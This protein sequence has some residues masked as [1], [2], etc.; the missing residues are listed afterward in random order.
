MGQAMGGRVPHFIRRFRIASVTMTAVVLALLLLPGKDIPHVDVPNV[1]KAVHFA[2]FWLWSLVLLYDW[3]S[4]ATRVPLLFII[5]TAMALGTETAQLFAINRSF[6]LRDAAFDLL[7][8][9]ASALTF[10]WPIALVDRLLDG[11]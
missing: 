3:R 2:M 5:G 1:D 9:A 4:L 11:R 7:G 10:K 6:D 8:V